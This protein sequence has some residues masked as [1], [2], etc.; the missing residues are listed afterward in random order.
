ML[1]GCK[2]GPTGQIKGI[3]LST[4]YDDCYCFDKIRYETLMNSLDR[5]TSNRNKDTK[6]SVFEKFSSTANQNLKI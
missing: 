3:Q 6:L 4:H 1:W 2:P 5:Y